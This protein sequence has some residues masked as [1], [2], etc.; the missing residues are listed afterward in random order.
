MANLNLHSKTI[1]NIDSILGPES[2]KHEAYK[3]EQLRRQRIMGEADAMG[4]EK[5]S[6][7]SSKEREQFLDKQKAMNDVFN[8][9]GQYLPP[10][11]AIKVVP[12]LDQRGN[13]IKDPTSDIFR[14]IRNNPSPIKII[15]P[16]DESPIGKKVREVAAERSKGLK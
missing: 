13:P 12:I 2:D 4:K 15:H 3:Q 5:L 1:R 16:R 9:G 10:G 14:Q 7:M 8:T 11:T 6:R